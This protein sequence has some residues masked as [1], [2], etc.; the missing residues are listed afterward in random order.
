MT[1]EAP[2]STNQSR[3]ETSSDHQERPLNNTQEFN[4]PVTGVA[5][6]VEGDQNVN[7][8][9]SKIFNNASVHIKNI[10]KKPINI[11]IAAITAVVGTVG[12]I[13]AGKQNIITIHGNVDR[14]ATVAN[15]LTIYQGD[16]P[17]VR[18]RKLEQ[19]KRLI[20]E[21]VL[22]NI[23]NLDARLGFVG[24]ALADDHFDERLRAVR[25]QVAPSL[26]QVFDPSYH[27]LMRQQEISSLRSA[28]T[29]RPLSEL[30]E[31]LIQVL[32]EG[33]ADPERVKAFYSSLTE[34][35]DVSESLLQELSTAA[36]QTST[37]PKET[38]HYQKRVQLGVARL[39]NRSQ[40]AH[41]SGLIALDSLKIALPTAQERLQTLQ[42]LE[43]RHIINQDEAVPLLVKQVEEAQRL[44]TERS[45]VVQEAETLR[46]K[47]LD[48]Y[49]Q[50]KEELTIQPSDS[51]KIVVGKAISL[52]QLGDTSGAVAAFSRYGEMF[53]EQDPTAVQYARTAQQ[54]TLQL[55]SLGV[56]GGVY[57]YEIVP[58]GSADRTGL[59]AGDIVIGYGDKT[60]TNMENITVALQTSVPDKPIQITYLR[61]SQTGVFQ[62]QTSTNIV[63]LGVGLMPI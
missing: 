5:G 20:A 45:A 10:I 43:P 58:G 13:F 56:Q 29:S 15:E 54:F 21:E 61:M 48:Q 44:A 1:E 63:P 27:R 16:P 34:V 47:A 3:D 50:L 52:R 18:Q 25:N 49:G 35:Q 57:I 17:E 11:A 55:N 40:T 8:S 62:R 30:R 32:I 42:H 7:V 19:A 12:I 31:S 24:T 60:I 38:E 39:L 28:F 14:G 4:E 46:D 37:D 23:T 51:W 59:K 41:I 22:A 9:N 2:D 6:N 53:A 26:N 33:N 36:A